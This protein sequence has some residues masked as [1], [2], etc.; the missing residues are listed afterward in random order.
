MKEALQD[1]RMRLAAAIAADP[2]EITKVGMDGVA[3]KSTLKHA[4]A[5]KWVGGK[6]TDT[7]VC[8]TCLKEKVAK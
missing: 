6:M 4:Y 3:V 5:W 1:E 2:C 8:S 7:L